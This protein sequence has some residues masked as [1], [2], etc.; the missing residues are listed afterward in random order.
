MEETLYIGNYTTNGIN[1]MHIKNNK[2]L[3]NLQFGTQFEIN[4]H[5]CKYKDYIY[6][7]AENR[8]DEVLGTGYV[9][10]YKY[11]ND[12]VLFLNRKSTLGEGPCYLTIDNKREIIYI[13]NYSTGS[14]IVYKIE[15]DGRIG[16][17]LLF[18]EYSKTS[19]I[20]HVQFSENMEKLFITDI[21]KNKLI[22]YLIDYNDE[23]L[24]LIYKSEYQFEENTRP[25]HIAVDNNVYVVS[26]DSCELF[27]F[28]NNNQ[29]ELL[30]KCS[31]L[32]KNVQIEENYTGCAIK[33]DKHNKY[34]YVS[35]RGHN[36]ISVFKYVPTLEL[37]QSISCGGNCPR[38]IEFSKD[39]KHLICANYES[40]NL[41]IFSINN[42][43]LSFEKSI[44]VE[45]PTCIC[46]K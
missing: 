34:I 33:I 14:I 16:D 43:L 13:C 3:S 1:V 38:D 31:I 28:K 15:K 35:V 7:V 29:L 45:S 36:S 23:K 46:V 40:N 19:Q 39:M 25:R 32:E 30:E 10:A 26:E 27:K 18:Q 8:L 12:K 37:I 2:I 11:N 24:S 4:A 22:E 41:S 42:G 17:Q 9:V 21:G 44:D 5:V 20:H 6:C